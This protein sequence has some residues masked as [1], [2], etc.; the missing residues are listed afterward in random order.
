MRSFAL[1]A[2]GLGFNGAGFRAT[3]FS[4]TTVSSIELGVPTFFSTENFWCKYFAS[5]SNLEIV[6]WLVRQISKYGKF[7][8]L[9]VFCLL[10]RQLD[11][12]VFL[13]K[14]MIHRRED[15]CHDILGEKN[16]H[17]SGRIF[18]KGYLPLIWG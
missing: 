2:M 7:V 15:L 16:Q 6:I 9:P 8:D 1:G 11:G 4:D 3:R 10:I 18:A 14:S 13:R 17:A 12:C 5:A